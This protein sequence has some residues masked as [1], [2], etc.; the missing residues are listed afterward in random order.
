MLSVRNKSER[1][2]GEVRNGVIYRRE[3]NVVC[4]SSH[5][6][7]PLVLTSPRSDMNLS[8]SHHTIL[9]DLHGLVREEEQ[10]KINTVSIRRRDVA[11]NRRVVQP[12]L[13]PLLS[14]F[15]VL[16]CEAKYSLKAT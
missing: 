3:T 16:D 10:V 9:E 8:N 5:T 15:V 1:I 2:E 4:A 6:S 14:L 7:S 12:T 11:C 13:R